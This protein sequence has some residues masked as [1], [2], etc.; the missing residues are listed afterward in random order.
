MLG[1]SYI[2]PDE[3]VSPIE[4]KKAEA[5]KS[6][7]ENTSRSAENYCGFCREKS[8][9]ANLLLC[10]LCQNG[11]HQT[12][13]NMSTQEF[14]THKVNA[15]WQCWSCEMKMAQNF[16]SGVR[17]GQ[18]IKPQTQQEQSPTTS[19]SP[20]I[21]SPTSTNSTSNN[22]SPTN[23]ICSPS[24]TRGTDDSNTTSPTSPGI[25][26]S[27][28]AALSMLRAG[29]LSSGSSNGMSRT[30]SM[31]DFDAYEQEYANIKRRR[32]SEYHSDSLDQQQIATLPPSKETPGYGLVGTGPL[33][34]EQLA[35]SYVNNGMGW[36]KI[37]PKEPNYDDTA[38]PIKRSS[39]WTKEQDANL[40][41]AVLMYNSKNW[42][43]ISEKVGK[44]KSHIQCLHR[45]QKVLD[46]ELVKGPWTRDE[47]QIITDL[48][49]K[50]GPKRWSLIAKQL[51]GRTG[52][53]CRERWINQLD[54]N[55]SKEPWTALE[56]ILL[57]QT[58]ESLGNKWAE[59]AKLLPGR[60]DNAVKNRWNGTL[61]RKSQ[62]ELETA[63]VRDEILAATVSQQT[64]SVKPAMVKPLVNATNVT[65]VMGEIL[66]PSQVARVRSAP[67]NPS[68][69]VQ[70]L[71]RHKRSASECQDGE[72][73]DSYGDGHNTN[74]N[75]LV[76]NPQMQHQSPQYIQPANVNTNT[77]NTNPVNNATSSKQQPQQQ[78]QQ[79]S[80]MIPGRWHFVPAV[81]NFNQ[82]QVPLQAIQ[83]M[84][85]MAYQQRPMAVTHP[86]VTHPEG[87]G[88]FFYQQQQ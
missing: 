39:M 23:S 72:S 52:K 28:V 1:G 43:A 25:P 69:G 66:H 34:G 53:Q 49:T 56:D 78:Q 8:P 80:D 84:Q 60:S 86:A 48:V 13:L 77:V 83:P 59:I 71:V 18:S 54:P 58:R 32:S 16:A 26:T 44:D 12:C 11:S 33:N 5:L 57:C 51:V 88:Q 9:N 75:V 4:S 19:K 63:R 7:P 82:Q 10:N 79:S 47:D 62:H 31:S 36:T 85:T 61:R 87:S 24:P 42:K 6:L 15:K 2:V 3:N 81:T 37:T 46:P 65:A 27:A 35:T 29:R 40:V 64:Q 50:H 21:A 55:I 22:S 76:M 70:Q 67:A 73:R 45:W 30:S 17:V 41:K 68:C 74:S 38:R 14:E 20:L